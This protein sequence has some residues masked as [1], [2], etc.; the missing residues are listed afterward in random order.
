MGR[1]E[2]IELPAYN[3]IDDI[4]DIDDMEFVECD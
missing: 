3:D 1:E 2:S 4:D